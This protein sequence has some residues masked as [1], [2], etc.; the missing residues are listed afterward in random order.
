M[1]AVNQVSSKERLRLSAARAEMLR[2]MAEQPINPQTLSQEILALARSKNRQERFHALQKSGSARYV[3]SLTKKLMGR[4]ENGFCVTLPWEALRLSTIAVARVNNN[5]EARLEQLYFLSAA[6]DI[7]SAELQRRV[8]TYKETAPTLTAGPTNGHLKTFFGL[9]R[10]TLT[11]QSF[12]EEDR[13]TEGR[14]ESQTRGTHIVISATQLKS[15]FHG[16][17]DGARLPVDVQR[18][19][20]NLMT[21]ACE[22]GAE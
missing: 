14:W 4:G 10:N 17:R 9:A 11:A 2:H 12:A 18:A 15:A 19:Y 21:R 5:P 20:G 6:H 1:N 22:L 3:P 16:A 7:T 13:R 8:L